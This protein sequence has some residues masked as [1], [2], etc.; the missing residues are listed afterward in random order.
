[1]FNLTPDKLPEKYASTI[2][3]D[4]C[5]EDPNNSFQFRNPVSVE[6]LYE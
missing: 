6:V 4:V 5:T 2:C 3:C 1:M